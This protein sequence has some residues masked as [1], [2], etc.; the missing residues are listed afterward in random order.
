MAT[1]PRLRAWAHGRT[2]EP[3]PN[4]RRVHRVQEF[5]R[6]ALRM[7]ILNEEVAV[8][9][10]PSPDGKGGRE[11][12]HYGGGAPGEAPALRMAGSGDEDTK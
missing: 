2:S 6:G 10:Y 12:G 4:A 5:L 3:S 8:G 9:A 1:G 7:I 11:R